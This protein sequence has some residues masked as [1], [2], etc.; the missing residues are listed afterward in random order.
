MASQAGSSYAT[1]HSMS[2]VSGSSSTVASQQT[3]NVINAT[4]LKTTN[5][6]SCSCYPAKTIDP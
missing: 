6:K 5:F 3:G 4:R 1:L 2:Q